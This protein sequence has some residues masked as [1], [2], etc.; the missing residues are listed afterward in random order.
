MAV[1][2]GLGGVFLVVVQRR[3]GQVRARIA[4]QTQESLSD[5]T[6]ITQESLGVSGI[7]L[8][9][10]FGQERAEGERY[11]AAYELLTAP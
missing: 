7:L 3:V 1:F 4:T 6:A 10:A 2:A 11:R 5:M 9:K 8:A